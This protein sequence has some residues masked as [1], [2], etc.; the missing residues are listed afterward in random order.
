MRVHRPTRMVP[1]VAAKASLQ[2]RAHHDASSRIAAEAE[3]L[4]RY[5]LVIEEGSSKGSFVYKIL[6]WETGEVLRQLPSE[7]VFEMRQSDDYG[8]GSIINSIV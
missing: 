7:E 1:I 2:S 6:D 3:R 4:A 8:A 5:R